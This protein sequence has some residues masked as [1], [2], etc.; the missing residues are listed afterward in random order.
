VKRFWKKYQPSD[1][2]YAAFFVGAGGVIA[3][4]VESG[5]YDD[6]ERSATAALIPAL[7]AAYWITDRGID[8]N[9]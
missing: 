1:K 7:I 2:W 9:N 4:W 6:A 5:A 3:S 8:P